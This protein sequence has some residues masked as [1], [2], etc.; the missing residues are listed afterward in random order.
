M[1]RAREL[2]RER[3]IREG[4]MCLGDITEEQNGE[5]LGQRALKSSSGLES[6]IGQVYLIY[7]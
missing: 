2:L 7:G 3:K 5:C 6:F 4:L 1:T